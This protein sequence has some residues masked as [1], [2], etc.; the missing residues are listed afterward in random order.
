MAAYGVTNQP[1]DFVVVIDTSGSMSSGDEPIYPEV[2]AAYQAFVASISDDDHLSLITFDQVATLRFSSRVG[3]SSRD[4]ALAALPKEATGK[5]TSMGSGLR[6]VIGQLGRADA[7]DVQIVL[8]LTD[9]QPTDGGDYIALTGPASAATKGRQVRVLGVGLGGD[10]KTGAP[11]LETVFPGVTTVTA[12]PNDQ[13]KKFFDDAVKRARITHL[14][15]PILDEIIEGG[16]VVEAQPRELSDPMEVEIRL[17][18]D[19]GKLGAKVTVENVVISDKNGDP[20]MTTLDGRRAT[21]TLAPGEVSEPFVAVADTKVPP[22]PFQ[23]GVTREQEY[24]R[25]SVEGVVRVEPSD[26]I[27][28][29]VDLETVGKLIEPVQMLAQRDIGI[30]YWQV[31]VVAAIAVLLL[32]VCWFIWYRFFSVPGLHGY[33]K[34]VK[35][36]SS[37]LRGRKMVVG[38]GGKICP[39]GAGKQSVEFYTQRAKFSGR[40]PTVF[41]KG[42]SPDAQITKAGRQRKLSSSVTVTAGTQLKLDR[43]YLTYNR[44]NS[45]S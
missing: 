24:V 28:K 41:V 45:S 39:D 10:E 30:P 22:A 25:A 21:I 11:L 3:D 33:L 44:T 40:K 20:F 4:E 8:F 26:E 32:Y 42:L 5:A 34:D 15:Q 18:N 16:I 2:I 31:A 13:L 38:A 23:I 9:G 43:A 12:L 36:R 19:Y 37:R 35:G 1:A 27:K 7:H 6:E 14:Y 29:A 17:R